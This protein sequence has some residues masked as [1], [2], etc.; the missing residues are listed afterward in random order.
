VLCQHC[1]VVLSDRVQEPRRSL[2]IREEESEGAARGVRHETRLT[3]AAVT[4]KPRSGARPGRSKPA[5]ASLSVQPV[6]AAKMSVLPK[7]PGQSLRGRRRGGVHVVANPLLIDVV[8]RLARG[9]N[10]R[11]AT[12]P[13]R[14]RRSPSK[15]RL[16][17]R[18]TLEVVRRVHLCLRG[19]FL[20]PVAGR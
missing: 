1:G 2:H 18:S 13:A 16:E 10:K 11:R 5:P 4:A 12:L 20:Q 9:Q 14:A 8:A 3:P 6:V 7:G 17:L 19:R 15:A